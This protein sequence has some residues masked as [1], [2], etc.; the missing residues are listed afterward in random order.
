[1]R[2]AIQANGWQEP[3]TQRP[4]FSF[5]KEPPP[6]GTPVSRVEIP[7][8]NYSP[9]E[10][11]YDEGKGAYMRWVAGQPHLDSENGQISVSN[12][13]VQWVK[14]W[15]T[16]ILEDSMGGRS[17]QFELTGEGVAEIFRDGKAYPAH[18]V[19]HNP[20]EITKFLDEEGRPMPF[21]PGN[22][23]IAVVPIGMEIT[24]ES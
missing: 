3:E 7:F 12:I 17:L 10:Y 23:W 2:E 11:R 9:A 24:K 5:D 16:D 8:S 6:G 14:S 15:E 19:R 21:K 18:W 13:I 4:D 20:D 1:M 22:I